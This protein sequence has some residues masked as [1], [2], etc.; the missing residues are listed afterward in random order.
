MKHVNTYKCPCC[1]AGVNIPYGSSN[2]PCEYCGNRI[3]VSLDNEEYAAIIG[4]IREALNQEQQLRNQILQLESD[5]QW[6]NR[7]KNTLRPSGKIKKENFVS[8]I[9][10]ISFLA[11]LFI[12]SIIFYNLWIN[13]WIEGWICILVLAIVLTVGVIVSAICHTSISHSTNS[14]VQDINNNIEIKKQIIN[15][16]RAQLDGYSKILSDNQNHI[17][18]LRRTDP[19]S[20]EYMQYVLYIGEAKTIPEACRLNEKRIQDSHN[21]AV[22]AKRLRELEETRLRNQQRMVELE[23]NRIQYERDRMVELEREKNTT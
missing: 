23:R 18:L 6:L 20:L 8:I 4:V 2:A 10:G 5:L 14:K 19:G 17:R 22:E 16:N 3:T 15:K 11:S 13:S 7:K 21:K 1:G 12:L 9:I